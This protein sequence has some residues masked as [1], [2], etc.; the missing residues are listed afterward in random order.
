VCRT[1]FYIPVPDR[2]L[3]FF[4]A[5]DAKQLYDYATIINNFFDTK[6]KKIT[7]QPQRT[8]QQNLLRLPRYNNKYSK[9]HGQY[10]VPKIFNE[11][12]DVDLTEHDEMDKIKLTIRRWLLLRQTSEQTT[13]D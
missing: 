8:R 10:T 5:L 4:H 1:I 2:Y 11:I 13:D 6:Y 9:R 3:I 7:T 12:Q